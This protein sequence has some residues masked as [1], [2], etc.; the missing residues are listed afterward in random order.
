MRLPSSVMRARTAADAK[1]GRGG[2]RKRTGAKRTG[3]KGPKARAEQV[4]ETVVGGKVLLRLQ[5]LELERGIE[6]TDARQP[7][8]RRPL[9]SLRTPGLRPGVD[10]IGSATGADSP[11]LEAHRQLRAMQQ[12]TADMAMH[13]APA[14]AP[15][16][17][18]PEGWRPIGPF[19][20]P[21]GQTYGSG[22]GSRPP[23]AGRVS[24]IAVDPASATHILV[25]AAGGGVWETRDGAL[26]W[27]PRT[28]Q[29]PSLATGAI[30]FDPST[31]QTV[32][33]GTGEG[34]FYAWLGAGLLRSIDG[35]TTW[36][37]RASAPFVGAGFYDLVVDPLNGQHLLAATTAGLFESADGGATW[38]SRR[39]QLTWDLSMHPAAGPNT[40]REVFAGCSDGLQVSSDGGT[41]WTSVALPG[42]PA[43][44]I[45]IEVAHAPS[46]GDV[47]YVFAAGT[48]TVAG[49]PWVGYIWRR[50]AAGGAFTAV[51]LPPG[52]AVGQAWYD[53]CAGVAPND[54][55]L[56][57]VAGIDVHRGARSAANVWTWTTISAKTNA[58]SIHPDQHHITFSPVD[59]NV[60][61]VG[62]D[63][64]IYRSPDTGNTWQ[65]L[66]KG[67]QITEFEYL[68]SHPQYDA[69]VIGGTQDN[70]TERYESGE[71]WFHVQDGDGGDCAINAATP[72]TCFHTFY[73]MSVERSLT[74]GGWGSWSGIG[75]GV[76]AGYQAL[77]YPPLEANGTVLARAGQ[78]VFISTD[79][80]TTWSEVA[81]PAGQVATA[82]AI[83]TAA[84]VYAG[85]WSGNLYRIDL[86]GATW[87]PAV[88]LTTPR[89][90][91]ISDLLVDPLN[92][93]RLWVTF[94]NVT[95][96]HVYRSDNGGT[97]W[98]DMSAGLPA[99]SV[100]AVVVDPINS[101]NVY[102]AA[103]VGVYRSVN[104]GVTW[105]AFSNQL[106]N[107]LAADLVFHQN[108]RLLRV[109][110][111]NRGAWEINVDRATMPD[112]EVYLRDSAVDTGR[113]T[114]SPS[115][116]NPFLPPSTQTYWWECRD[117]KVDSPPYQF[118]GLADV[119][120]QRFEDDH[121]VAAAGL[122]HENAER[123][124]KVR[125]FAQVHNRGVQPAAN[126][127]VKVFYASAA[128]GLP[129]LPAGFWT[130]F[131]NNVLAASS[132][133]QPIAPHQV[134]PVIRCGH[135]EV[136]TFE[137]TVPAAQASHTC[138]LAVTSAQND[139]IATAELNIGSL[140][141]GQ[142]KCG[143]KN[144]AVVN[145]T[146]W[147]WPFFLID[148]WWFFRGGSFLIGLDQE[149]G[150][151]VR[152]V[153]LNRRYAEEARRAKHESR[154]V[155]PTEKQQLA[156]YL[157]ERPHL[158]GEDFELGE[159]FVPRK[160]PWLKVPAL[161]KPEPD[162]LIVVFG[163]RPKPG[164]FALVQ[165]TADGL[166]AGGFTFEV[167]GKEANQ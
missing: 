71:V 22:T 38:A 81:L 30:A 49:A 137:W 106:P 61:Y 153:L 73:G 9:D 99:I 155:T 34:D 91:Y 94:S 58:D 32:Y 39:A 8:A 33:A 110:T 12:P 121:G 127:A 104:A 2:G 89:A 107:A 14:P 15:A 86:V 37:V 87:Q 138:L 26:T 3:A 135:P 46:N 21:H 50:A 1:A 23:V 125:V 109:G 10:Q 67:L 131:P 44:W 100:N 60:V 149:V 6:Q 118:P 96:S 95:G 45:R 141:L 147:P 133:W 105:T 72:A 51:P 7:Q 139:S 114:P 97:T 27:F 129:N 64:G 79:S 43:R 164:R 35:G 63:G 16:A 150:E 90:G 119:D 148:V 123:T 111:R 116:P 102:L 24:S 25:G 75:P 65:A 146:F 161:D 53:W 29:Q 143:L 167:A 163:P 108:S 157:R 158:K 115:G 120:F 55:D 42:A 28:D 52:L 128:L 162:R 17:S 40:T 62:N 74:G 31:P 159:L 130:N 83:P 78:S 18:V 20:V 84:R 132:P 11:Y 41:T 4:P 101:N 142:I 152:G 117:L 76:P 134:V 113:R 103:D 136:V 126:V 54:P 69:W 151:T 98:A 19:A 124:K 85:T 77:F 68:A 112:V 57:Y 47:V 160:G 59:P 56:L 144:L 92:A 70:G 48:T 140:V 13:G 156:K 88:A 93:L 82:L 154:R 122:Q 80:G 5:Q 66:N 165:W 36:N 166:P 145:P